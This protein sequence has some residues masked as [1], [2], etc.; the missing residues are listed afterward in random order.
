VKF[1]TVITETGRRSK[2]KVR[3]SPVAS[4]SQPPRHASRQ[5]GGPTA[6]SLRSGYGRRQVA[7]L[8]Q[9][10]KRGVPTGRSGGTWSVAGPL[11]VADV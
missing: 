2:S 4:A 11:V 5:A 8:L 9:A 3:S 6:Q 7:K 10:D 1:R